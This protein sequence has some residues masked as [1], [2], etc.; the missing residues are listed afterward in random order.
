ME[1]IKIS[2]EVSVNLSKETQSFLAGLFNCNTA[3]Q[4]RV[5]VE[6][7]ATEP[8]SATHA[9]M[10]AAEPT[11]ATHAAMPAAEPVK[12]SEVA[13]TQANITIEDVR[14]VLLEKI[15]DNR[16]A[17]KQK[18]TELGAPSVTKLD[19]SKYSELYNFLKSL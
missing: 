8:A 7:P 5:P 17:I 14:G 16:D 9:V 18:L 13:E 10:P 19:P 6:A 12:K 15:N 11:S 3:T 2:V 1:T 4:T